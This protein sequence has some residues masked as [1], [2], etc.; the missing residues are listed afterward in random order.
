M[1]GTGRIYSRTR[2][3]AHILT[4]KHLV[5]QGFEIWVDREFGIL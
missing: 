3:N 2:V 4:Y 1:S 5:L